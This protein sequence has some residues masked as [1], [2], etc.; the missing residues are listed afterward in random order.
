MSWFN[1]IPSN[2]LSGTRRLAS[3]DVPQSVQRRFADLGSWIY[4]YVGPEQT[5]RVT[6]LTC[7]LLKTRKISTMLS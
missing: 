4:D 6:M 3:A 2:V 1:R 7:F 5:P